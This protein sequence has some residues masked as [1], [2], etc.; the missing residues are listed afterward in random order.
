MS[1][2]ITGTGIKGSDVS[3]VMNNITRSGAVENLG[4]DLRNIGEGTKEQQARRIALQFEQTFIS[5]LLKE[6][7]KD[8]DK[9]DGDGEEE[10]LLKGGSFKSIRL[11]F[12]SQY[13]AD[14]GGIGYSQVIEEQLLEKIR[15]QEQPAKT[16]EPGEK[17]QG[18]PLNREKE[19]QYFSLDGTRTKPALP[20]LRRK[21][22]VEPDA[23]TPEEAREPELRKTLAPMVEKPDISNLRE[24]IPGT[25]KPTLAEAPL[26][27]SLPVTG[28]ISSAYGWRKDPIDGVT[29]FH[30]GID[31]DV[32]P[33][34][35]V[36]SFMEGEVTAC[37]WEKGYGRLVEI[38]HP[39]G[40]TTRYGHNSELK[41]KKGDKVEAGAVVALSGSSGRST[42][43][44]LHFEIRK[45]EY[46]LDPSTLIAPDLYARK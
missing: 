46:A 37:G 14:N 18:L 11:M 45:G 15:G 30:N 2:T 20:M 9:E 7:F 22:S 39:N 42:G 8:E 4:L 31:F 41:V 43:P 3:T 38:R 16:P 23:A 1:G 13:I 36:L 29:R 19:T 33:R 24:L 17:P 25:A 27:V 40:L 12:L 35:P 32:P 44:H 5:T 10:K 21:L 6:A 26:R 28:K 34:T